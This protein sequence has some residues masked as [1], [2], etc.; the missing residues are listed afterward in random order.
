MP[1]LRLTIRPEHPSER[2]IHQ[3]V[4]V[5]SDGGVI[6]CPTDTAYAVACDL[7]SRRSIERIY[8]MK[9]I[10]HKKPLSLVC[11]DLAEIARYASVGNSQYRVLR[12]H[13]PGPYTFILPATKE[14]PKLFE[15]RAK[16]VGIRVP[17][18]PA[19]LKIVRQLRHPLVVTTASILMEDELPPEEEQVTEEGAAREI[20][21]DPEVIMRHFGHHVELFLD[22]DS[23]PIRQST[24]VDLTGATP[25][26]LRTGTGAID[27]M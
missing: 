22:G 17:N 9:R 20:L 5:L 3:A 25:I 26:V 12:S 4:E 23:L 6:I 8:A 24:V 18:H 7:Y 14:V 2:A 10:P 16:T 27:R 21:A 13:L 11:A 15:N 19:I 1:A